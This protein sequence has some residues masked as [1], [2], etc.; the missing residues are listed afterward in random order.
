MNY[1]IIYI[2]VI[3]YFDDVNKKNG[4]TMLVPGSHR[5]LKYA[6]TSKNIKNLKYI[7]AKKGLYLFLILIYGMG[8]VKKLILIAKD[9]H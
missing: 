6:I 3:W 4:T 8:E 2:N 7:N 9:G 5:Y 1:N